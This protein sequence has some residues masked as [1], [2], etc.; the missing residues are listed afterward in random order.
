MIYLP[1]S[2]QTIVAGTTAARVAIETRG[3]ETILLLEDEPE[4]ARL[5]KD[6][7]SDHGYTVLTATRPS[8]ALQI[9]ERHPGAIGL[10]LTDVVMPEM[11]GPDLAARLAA[12]R[13]RLLVLYMSGYPDGTR[14]AHGQFSRG[15]KL[16]LKPFTAQDLT[17]RVRAVLDRKP[18]TP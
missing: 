3:T 14:A 4:V 2:D 15:L 10:L 12:L 18:T 8:E 17:T 9:A 6:I 11:S 1:R 5:A 16:L 7:L 13:P